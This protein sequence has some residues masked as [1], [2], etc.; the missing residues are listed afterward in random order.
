MLVRPSYADTV[1]IYSVSR[2]ETG[3]T[4]QSNQSEDL[5]VSSEHYLFLSFFPHKRTRKERGNLQ[6]P[7]ASTPKPCVRLRSPHFTQRARF[8]LL[9]S[10]TAVLL[11]V[12]LRPNFSFCSSKRLPARK[13]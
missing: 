3:R 11:L 13:Q 9:D 7:V 2:Q 1:Y 8:C 6:P 10:A 4:L 12:K 5:G